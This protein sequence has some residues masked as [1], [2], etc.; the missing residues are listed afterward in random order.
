MNFDLL[1]I[2]FSIKIHLIHTIDKQLI[3]SIYYKFI[4]LSIKMKKSERENSNYIIILTS[5][6]DGCCTSQYSREASIESIKI[7][8]IEINF[9]HLDVK[10]IGRCQKTRSIIIN[11]EKH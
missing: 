1:K 8:R 5:C 3:N 11:E 10:S 7:V 2:K 6:L 4:S 9:F